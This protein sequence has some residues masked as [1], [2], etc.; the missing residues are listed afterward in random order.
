MVKRHVYFEQP[1]L[2]AALENYSHEV[3]HAAARS[4]GSRNLWTKSLAEWRNRSALSLK[5]CRRCAGRPSLQQPRSSPRSAVSGSSRCRELGDSDVNVFFVSSLL[6]RIYVFDTIRGMPRDGMREWLLRR[7]AV[8]SVLSAQLSG[9]GPGPIAVLLLD[10]AHDR[11]LF[12]FRDD[13]DK[14]TN[15]ES[16][17]VLEGMRDELANWASEQG[18]QSLYLMFLDTLSNAVT[19][20]D[21]REVP[22]DSDLPDY[23]DH[24][25][26]KEVANVRF[27][28]S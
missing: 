10:V 3:E 25:F 28:R 2:D 11:L 19:I 7:R 15:E 9:G 16:L 1:A 17:P 27:A 6:S 5:R 22:P 18:A 12:R 26:T 24:I 23:L 8:Y 20:S 4:D 13:L 21:P 14:I